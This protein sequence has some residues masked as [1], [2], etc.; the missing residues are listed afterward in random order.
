MKNG[1]SAIQEQIEQLR[2]ELLELQE[3]LPVEWESQAGNMDGS[4]RYRGIARRIVLSAQ[5]LEQ[6][7]KDNTFQKP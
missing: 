6:L 1:V 7:V 3:P 4:R 2:R 5:K